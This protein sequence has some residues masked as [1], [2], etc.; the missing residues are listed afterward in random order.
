MFQYVS[1]SCFTILTWSYI[2]QDTRYN[3]EV[4][5][6]SGYKTASLLCMPVKNA[7]EEIV[8][9]VQVI[10]KSTE[11]SFST[12]DEKVILGHWSIY[13]TFTVVYNALLSINDTNG[14]TI[15]I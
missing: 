15:D 2:F 3:D 14:N 9:V 1:I 5:K 6:I 4:D 8:A 11:K 12:E 7:D 13:F 10:N